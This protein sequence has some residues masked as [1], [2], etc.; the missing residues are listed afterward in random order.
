MT[1]LEEI[2]ISKRKN[3][4]FWNANLRLSIIS[5]RAARLSGQPTALLEIAVK[6]QLRNRAV[7]EFYGED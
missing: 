7:F 1:T 2:S 3:R 4:E 6:A 5:L